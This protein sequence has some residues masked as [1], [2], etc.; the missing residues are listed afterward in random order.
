MQYPLRGKTA[1]VTGGSR[2][3]GRAI[4]R[5]LA[6][7]GA[8]VAIHYGGNEAAATE[9]MNVIKQAGGEAFLIQAELGVHGDI[10]TLFSKLEK[11]L[12]GRPLDILVNNAA[13]SNPEAT[14]TQTT[15]EEFD[16][17]FAI[18]VRAPFF[19]IQRALPLMPDGGRIINISSG[20]TWFATSAIVYSM[21]KGALNVLGR[22]L[23]N[24]LGVRNITVNT[25]SPGITDTDMNPSI[26][27]KDTKT[28]EQVSAMTALG[29]P[30][31]P[32]DIG[33]VV[34]FFASDDARWITGQTLE[35]N[36]GLFLGPREP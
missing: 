13:V 28:I 11:E 18:N 22:S 20:V 4:A 33:D 21:T 32:A 25:I 36:G 24:S 16:R 5:R 9:T 29:R 6:V 2:G 12:R 17:I 30:G 3:I 27:G 31:H 15:P 10:D 34:A 7:G 8:L 26:R 23:A 19:I 1:L 14:I 35:V